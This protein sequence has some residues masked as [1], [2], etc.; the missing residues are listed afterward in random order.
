MYDMQKITLKQL[1]KKLMPYAPIEERMRAKE[2][3]KKL[4]RIRQEELKS[5]VQTKE[6]KVYV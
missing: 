2:K 6:K 5:R 4:K 1:L 3:A